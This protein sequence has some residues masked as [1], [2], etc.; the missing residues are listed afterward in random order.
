MS[1]TTKGQTNVAKSAEC[2]K[3]QHM[4]CTKSTCICYKV[5]YAKI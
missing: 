3:L 4:H 1:L 2:T 5:N